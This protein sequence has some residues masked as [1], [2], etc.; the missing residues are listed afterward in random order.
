MDIENLYYMHCSVLRS[1]NQG[2]LKIIYNKN[3]SAKLVD[4]MLMSE[5][6]GIYLI[7]W[8][9]LFDILLKDIDIIIEDKDKDKNDYNINN[10]ELNAYV[11]MHPE[12]KKIQYIKMFARFYPNA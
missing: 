2:A 4:C 5:I 7:N 9:A 1:V 10:M 12:L 8:K 6:T 3:G 11:E